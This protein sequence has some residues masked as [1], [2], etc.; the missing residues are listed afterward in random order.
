[1]VEHLE[2]N[3][4]EIGDNFLKGTMPVDHRTVQPMGILHMEVHLLHWLKPWEVSL[5]T[6]LSTVRKNIV[7][8][9]ILMPIIFVLQKED[10]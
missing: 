7:L 8:V 2:I 9:W 6:S 5:P 1:M 4:T 10:W 3:I